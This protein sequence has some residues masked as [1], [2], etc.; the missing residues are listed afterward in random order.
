MAPPGDAQKALDLNNHARQQ[1]SCP[2][3]HWDDKLA[4]DATAY[5]QTLA[6]KIGH[7]SHST[8]ASRP[9]QGENLFW[10]WN[11]AKTEASFEAGVQSWLNE[12]N[13]YQK[14]EKIGQG[15]FASYGHYTQCLWKKTTKCG[16]GRAMDS[17][18]GTYIVGR[19]SPPG[20]VTGETP[21]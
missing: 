7:L 12:A 14:G 1:H 20:N 10:S 15:D 6:N 17:K 16:L 3:L 21:Y 8:N 13:K 5:A 2:P 11:S 4:A 19:Y 9:G 18:G